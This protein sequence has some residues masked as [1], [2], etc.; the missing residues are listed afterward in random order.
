MYKIFKLPYHKKKIKELKTQIQIHSCRYIAT[1]TDIYIFIY[2]CI[3]RDPRPGQV[4]VCQMKRY[5]FTCFNF[6]GNCCSTPGRE[7][8]QA[9]PGNKKPKKPKL[10]TEQNTSRIQIPETET[11]T[12]SLARLWVYF[13]FL[14][15]MLNLLTAVVFLFNLFYLRYL[16]SSGAWSYHLPALEH[17]FSFF[18]WQLATGT[19]GIQFWLFV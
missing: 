3:G 13:L 5:V 14:S 10:R 4:H 2:I 16:L 19:L 1:D 7:P 15:E 18:N 6:L 11:T 8:G 12:G 17:P 9:R